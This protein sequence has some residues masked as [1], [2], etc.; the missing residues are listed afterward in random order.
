MARA[1][2]RFCTEENF[3]I[4]P[5]LFTHKFTVA[6]VKANPDYG[7]CQKFVCGLACPEEFDSAGVALNFGVPVTVMAVFFIIFGLVAGLM[8]AFLVCKRS[9]PFW[10]AT[11][12]LLAQGL[13]SNATLGAVTL[14]YK[15][16]WWD[17]AVLPIGLGISLI[18]NGL[19]LAGPINRMHVLSV[20]EM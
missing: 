4:S 16:G 19:T 15:F 6:Q 1:K 3:E 7:C 11:I 14:G 17:G 12:A 2:G 5:G 18:I 20:P 10:I 8:T 13:D 9:L